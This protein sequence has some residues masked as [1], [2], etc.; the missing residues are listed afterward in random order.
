[1]NDEN[2]WRTAEEN[3][4]IAYQ[5]SGHV[6]LVRQLFQRELVSATIVPSV[7]YEGQSKWLDDGGLRVATLFKKKKARLL[8]ERSSELVGAFFKHAVDDLMI[9]V[10]GEVVERYFCGCSAELHGTD[11]DD[12][13]AAANV[14]FQSVGAKKLLIAAAE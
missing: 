12:A 4:R 8:R 6:V 3:R 9:S 7:D 11:E 2:L 5:E 10:A 13:F 14:I 1:M